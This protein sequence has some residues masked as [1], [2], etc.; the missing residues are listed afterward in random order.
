M[1]DAVYALRLFDTHGVEGEGHDRLRP[2]FYPDTDVFVICAS[3]GFHK[4]YERA[5]GQW[6]P[7][8]E[9]YCPSV[10]ILLLGVK[11]YYDDGFTPK[12]SVKLGDE[13]NYGRRVAKKIGAVKYLECDPM[14]RLRVNS[15]FGEVCI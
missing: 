1:G 9:H 5:V 13:L 14:T 6:A 15:V 7:E 4:E 12:N 11:E 3:I 2:L 8:I 10:P